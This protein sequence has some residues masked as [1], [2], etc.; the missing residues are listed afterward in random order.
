M[1]NY[2]WFR[3]P[4]AGGQWWGQHSK[5]S[6]PAL[7]SERGEVRR[8]LTTFVIRDERGPTNLWEPQPVYTGGTSLNADPAQSRR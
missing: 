2:R 1:V 8:N 5:V 6:G 7:V 3:V 4:M